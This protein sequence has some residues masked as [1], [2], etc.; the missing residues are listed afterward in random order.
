LV[1]LVGDP[2]PPSYEQT[3]AAWDQLE[4]TPRSSIGGGDGAED[5]SDSDESDDTN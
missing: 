4:N 5:E 1:E 2:E 3:P